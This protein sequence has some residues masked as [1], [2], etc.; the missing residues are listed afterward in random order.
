MKFL[1]FLN[2]GMRPDFLVK[3]QRVQ[4]YTLSPWTLFECS[5]LTNFFQHQICEMEMC[6][7]IS[8]KWVS[9]S[10][11]PILLIPRGWGFQAPRTQGRSPGSTYSLHWPLALLGRD[12]LPPTNASLQ[13][14]HG[15][16]AQQFTQPWVACLGV[17][18]Q[19]FWQCRT[20][21]EWLLS[22]IFYLARLSFA[23]L[24]G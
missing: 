20:G 7:L 2:L 3:S 16:N 6:H 9:K 13:T 22:P 8:S 1:I 11:F 23:S 19:V 14:A 17:E 10:R 18:L 4:C 24:S 5:A 12:W 21:V 15:G